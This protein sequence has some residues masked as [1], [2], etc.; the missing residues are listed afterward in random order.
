MGP[1]RHLRFKKDQKQEQQQNEKNQDI[2]DIHFVF[3]KNKTK[4]LLWS[5]IV[6]I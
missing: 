1:T 3:E 6:P 2:D 4:Y 5:L